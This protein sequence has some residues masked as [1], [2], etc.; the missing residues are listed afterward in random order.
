MADQKTNT[1]ILAFIALVV[2]AILGL[3]VYKNFIEKTPE[4]KIAD[5]VSETIENIGNAVAPKKD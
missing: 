2:V 3:L 5:S 4:E 1:T